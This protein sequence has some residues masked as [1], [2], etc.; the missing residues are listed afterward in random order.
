MGL[1]I[2]D[3]KIDRRRHLAAKT[4]SGLV[5]NANNSEMVIFSRILSLEQTNGLI[6]STQLIPSLTRNVRC[7]TLRHL[8]TNADTKFLRNQSQSDVVSSTCH[9]L[10]IQRFPSISS[11]WDWLYH[12]IFTC[13]LSAVALSTRVMDAVLLKYR[14]KLFSTLDI[15]RLA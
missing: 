14:K 4:T 2:G 9:S 13:L 11:D 6:G 3:V 8:S 7:Q 1:S 10:I 15:R 5:K 12:V